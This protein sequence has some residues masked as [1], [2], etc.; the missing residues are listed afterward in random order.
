MNNLV[1]RLRGQSPGVRDAIVTLGVVA[2]AF[3]GVLFEWREGDIDRASIAAVFAIVAAG[4]I[5]FRR[6]NPLAVL[7]VVAAAQLLFTWDTGNEHTLLPAAVVALFTVA[8][9]ENRKAGLTAAAII[10]LIMAIGTAAFDSDRF[11]PEFAGQLALM[12]APTAIGDAVRSRADRVRDLIETEANSRVQA[13]QIRIAR[14]LHDVVAHGLSIIAIQSGVAAHLLDQ[15]P[16]QAKEALEV[17]NMTGKKSLEEL[18][19]MVGVL[20]STDDAP[21]LRPTPADPN[22][23]TELLE[24]AANAGID[25]TLQTTGAFPSH[26]GDSCV[27]AMH[28]IL[29]EALTNVARHAGAA[30][31]TIRIDHFVDH[32]E[33]HVSDSGGDTPNTE[34]ESTGVGII[35]MRERA[36]S[37]GGTLTAEPTADDGFQVRAVLPY[38]ATR[39]PTR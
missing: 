32:V 15:D 30:A 21:L 34:L 36:E 9:Q 38:N 37:V 6:Q 19:T 24:G 11:L 8:G 22:D 12:A 2:F 25:I 26:V 33:L 31:T 14:D 16:S 13:E 1:K 4:S 7:L 20:R 39:E 17:I 5:W 10:G 3:F 18:R 27:V 23:L 35:G 28:R 29:R